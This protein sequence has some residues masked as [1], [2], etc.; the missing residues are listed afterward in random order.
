[1]F[2]MLQTSA[3][4]NTDTT[5]ASTEL[6]HTSEWRHCSERCI[7]DNTP[8]LMHL[9]CN[10]GV[11]SPWYCT[12]CTKKAPEDLITQALLLRIK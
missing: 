9:P 1:M 6:E 2:P 4:G 3:S 7:W 5:E 12:K 8:H 11:S 10:L